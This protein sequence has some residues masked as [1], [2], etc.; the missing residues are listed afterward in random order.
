MTQRRPS[1]F[2]PLAILGGTFDPVHYGHLRCADEARRSLG[3][4]RL[5]LLP[6]GTPPHRDRPIAS[7]A[8]RLEMLRLARGEFPRLQVDARETRRRGPSYMVDTLQ[9]LHREFP[10]RPLILLIGQD[11]FNQLNSWHQWEK[12]FTYAHIVILTRPGVKAEYQQNLAEQ[13]R[14]RLTDDVQK[15]RDSNAG[16]VLVLETTPVDVSATR[17]KDTISRGNAPGAM[18]PAAVCDYIQQN[19]LYRSD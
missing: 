4:E 2:E 3:L 8:Q 10:H 14:Q 5:Y 17:I 9:E 16:A 18:L 19:H 15:L 1:C 11:A 12:L 13:F 6:S 7:T